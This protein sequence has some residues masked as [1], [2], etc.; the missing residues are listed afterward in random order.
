MKNKKIG[1]ALISAVSVIF[2]ALY[3]YALYSAYFIFKRGNASEIALYTVLLALCGGVIMLMYTLTDKKHKHGTANKIIVPTV[4]AAVHAGVYLAVGLGVQKAVAPGV[5]GEMAAASSCIMFGIALAVYLNG[6]SSRGHKIICRLTAAV[7]ALALICS[8]LV[9]SYRAIGNYS[10]LKPF[11]ELSGASGNIGGIPTADKDIVYDF[12]YATEKDIRDTAL[13]KDENIDIALAKNEWEGFQ[14]IFATTAKNKNV[15]VSVSD[16]K[17]ADGD[18]LKVE[19]YKAH[20]SEVKGM[21]DKY[22]CEYADALIPVTHTGEHGSPAELKK[23]LQQAFFIRTRAE[24]DTKAGE[25]TATVTAKNES[26][27]IILEKEIK[28]TVW[29]FTLPDA[30]A[31]ESAFGNGGG[32]FNTLS[33]V[34]DGDEAAGERLKLQLYN[35]LVENHLSPYNLP[36]D[37]LDE[38]ADKYMSDPRVTSFVIPYPDEDELLV[39]YYEK[40]TSNPEWAK[41]GY[42]YPIDEP[43]DSDAYARYKEITDRLARLCPGYNMVTPFNTDKVTIDGKEMSSVGLQT[44]KSSI[45]CGLSEVVDRG[46]TLEEMMSAVKDGSRAWWYVC[47][48][49]GGDYCNFFIHLDALKHRALM[50]QQKSLNITGLLYWST[51]YCD[52]ANPWESSKTWD[53]FES[54]GDGL[55]IYPGGYIGFDGPIPTIRLFNIADGMEDYDYFALAETKFGRAWVDERIAK[56]TQSPT[57]LISDHAAFE[58][59]RR[60]IGEA[61]NA[62]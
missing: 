24:K 32:T 4:S 18:T 61:L 62:K 38:C 47:C 20:Y 60:E 42:F 55:L 56:V 14:I 19:A 31:N 7:C 48:A 37:I 26:G 59:V 13:G 27:E 51:T 45:I 9:V 3:I 53:S 50:W 8:G 36:Y 33:G 17:N 12:A 35:L 40:V 39:K 46:T 58:Q 57:E 30:P 54:A 41:K 43:G 49:P 15:S 25:Y 52:K 28:A 5:A 22:N 2:T 29:N 6:L 21:G 34:K 23:G 44:G 1:T 11:Y 16:F 10:F